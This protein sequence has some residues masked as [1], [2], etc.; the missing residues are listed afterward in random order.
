[1]SEIWAREERV[2]ACVQ[3]RIVSPAKPSRHGAF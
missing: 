2:K 1:L 3:N